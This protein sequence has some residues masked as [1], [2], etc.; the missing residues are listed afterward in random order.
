MSTAFQASLSGSVHARSR[1]SRPWVRWTTLAIC[2]VATPFVVS[3]YWMYWICLMCINVISA[4][5]LNILT[6]YTGL[7]SLGQ[8]AFM[9][10]GA[11]T[12]ALLQLHLPVPFPLALLLAGLVAAAV[13]LL[14]GVPSL[15]VKGLYLAIATIAASFILEF[16]FVNWESVTNGTRGLTVPPATFFGQ[17]LDRPALL[18]WVIAPVT[19]L[20]VCMAANVFRTRVGRAFIAIRDRDI[21]AEVLGIPLLHYKLMSFGLSSFYA[22]LLLPS[23]YTGRLPN[24]AIDL[25][26]RRHHCGR[27]G[28]DCRG[29]CRRG[30]YD[31]DA[32]A[33]APGLWVASAMGARCHGSDSVGSLHRIRRIDRR[34]PA[35]RAPRHRGHDPAHPSAP[36]IA[37]TFASRDFPCAT[38]ALSFLGDL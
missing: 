22:G 25:L 8:A 34:L 30:L 9:G 19:L 1:T 7:S 33:A 35:V 14:V 31:N 29:Y 2:A 3:N 16:V 15:R 28:H 18:Y 23:S 36:G 11:Y 37:L 20:M 24:R 17:A 5:G 13:G 32:R 38:S 4:T 12:V 26:P 6:G 21:S 10:V 27:P